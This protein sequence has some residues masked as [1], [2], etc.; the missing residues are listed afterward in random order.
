MAGP[1]TYGKPCGGVAVYLIC[2]IISCLIYPNISERLP[3]GK[4]QLVEKANNQYFCR[5]HI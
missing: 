3:L 5:I 4:G 2:G 1:C